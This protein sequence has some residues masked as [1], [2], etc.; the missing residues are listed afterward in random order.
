MVLCWLLGVFETRSKNW[1]PRCTLCAEGK[2]YP[3]HKTRVWDAGEKCNEFWIIPVWG[4]KKIC[5][6]LS[7][8]DIF[9]VFSMADIPLKRVLRSSRVR[10]N[11]TRLRLCS[12]TVREQ[13]WSPGLV[14]E[15]WGHPR[16]AG[17]LLVAHGAE[18]AHQIYLLLSSFMG[19]VPQQ[20][21][22]RL[23]FFT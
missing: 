7:L 13:R 14:A 2:F 20:R 8:G 17:E 12:C 3:S 4:H 10:R 5:Y 15:V 9:S 16:A 22:L 19:S 1:G 23:S 11:R 18:K 6:N 21:W